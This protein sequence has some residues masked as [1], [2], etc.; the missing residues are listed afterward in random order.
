M[1]GE[2]SLRERTQMHAH[3]T[4]TQQNRVTESRVLNEMAKVFGIERWPVSAVKA[5]VGHSMASA[6][7]D[8]L[9]AAMGTWEFGWMPGITTVDHIAE[10]V[11]DSNLLLPMAHLQ[12]DPQKLEGAFINS[13]GFGGNNATGFFISPKT[14]EKMLTQRWGKKHMQAW[15][16]CNEA[17]SSAAADY[18]ERAEDGDFPPFYQL[19]DK[20][21]ES[22]DLS[23]SASE[24]RIPGFGQGV[25][26]NLAN[27]YAD[28]TGE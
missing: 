17:V 14:T 22:E 21:V 28:M 10:D 23:I 24:I 15:R 25:D 11:H 7:G 13:K 18:N 5:Y 9:A 12:I 16:K 20:V 4:G 26:L 6:G 8:Q 27:P 1:L 3:G 19:G 2:K